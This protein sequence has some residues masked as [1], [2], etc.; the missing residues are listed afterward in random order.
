LRGE[1]RRILRLK[2][3]MQHVGFVRATGHEHHFDGVIEKGEGDAVSGELRELYAT[4]C[5]L[6]F[7]A[8]TR[9]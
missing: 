3:L 2:N 7:L 1:W 4:P 9:A 8:A 6:A 5:A